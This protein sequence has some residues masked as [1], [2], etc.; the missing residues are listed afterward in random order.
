MG[1]PERR[2]PHSHLVA[3]GPSTRAES[4]EVLSPHLPTS[5]TSEQREN[6]AG[7]LLRKMRSQGRIRSRLIGGRRAWEVT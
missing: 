2:P 4:I 6:K 1:H 5:L 7:N 3:N